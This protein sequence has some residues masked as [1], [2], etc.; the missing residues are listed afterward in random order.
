MSS[1]VEMSF[2]EKYVF[3]VSKEIKSIVQCGYVHK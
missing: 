2:D 3:Q 1:T